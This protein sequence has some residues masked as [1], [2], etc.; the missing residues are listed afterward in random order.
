MHFVE[1]SHNLK[2]KLVSKQYDLDVCFSAVEHVRT[3]PERKVMCYPIQLACPA[4]RIPP[5]MVTS[6]VDG[7]TTTVRYSRDSHKINTAH[8]FK[9]VGAIH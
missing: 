7:E 5:N 6:N 4:P 2:V 1:K 9:L 8:M 3:P